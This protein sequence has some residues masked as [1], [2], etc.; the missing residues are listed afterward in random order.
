MSNMTYFAKGRRLEMDAV[1]E[2]AGH[3]ARLGEFET[4]PNWGPGVDTRRW[5]VW[6]SMKGLHFWEFD[7]SP[8]WSAKVRNVSRL[9]SQFLGPQEDYFPASDDSLTCRKRYAQSSPGPADELD[10]EI[11]CDLEQ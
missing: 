1:S 6:I 9:G 10:E 7:H 4:L 11:H 2:K 3:T 5:T 8:S